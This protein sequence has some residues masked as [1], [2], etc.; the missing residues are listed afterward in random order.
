MAAAAT[1]AAGKARH[2]QAIVGQNVANEL[3]GITAHD[4]A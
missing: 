3:G 4:I 1:V 2:H